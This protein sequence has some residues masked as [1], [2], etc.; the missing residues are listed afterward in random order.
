M[1][2]NLNRNL[3]LGFGLSVLL[4]VL[5]SIASY[6]SIR[7]LVESAKLVDHSTT[8]VQ[9]LELIISTMKDAETGQRGYLLTGQQQFL[10]PYRG[11]SDN[12]LDLVNEVQE[13]TYDDSSQQNHIARIKE[14]LQQRLGIL[15]TLIDKKDAGTHVSAADLRNGKLAMDELRRAVDI[16]EVS[17]R[18]VLMERTD[19]LTRLSHVTPIILLFAVLLAI[20]ISILFY[21]RVSKDIQEKVALQESL[22]E[23]D[24]DTVNRIR[25][26]QR[27]AAGISAG[28][29]G[30][31]LDV[32]GED[33]LGAISTALNKMA[34]NLEYSFNRI[35]ENEWMQTGLNQLN[36]KMIGE[37]GIGTLCQEA[38]EFL[39]DYTE[40]QV[41]AL[42]LLE[43]KVL[44]LESGFAVRDAPGHIPLGQGL[45]GHAALNNTEVWL[46]DMPDEY[47]TV[48]HATGEM[49][50]RHLII[51]PIRYE[52]GI[53]GVIEI[54]SIH[55]YKQKTL[56][57]LKNVSPN[58]ATVITRAEYRRRRQE[59]LEE[60]QAQSEELQ[61]Q[62][63][64]M[65]NLNAEL[66]AHTQ[67]LLASEEELRVQQEELQQRND[68]LA[69]RNT[70]ITQRN[71]EIRQTA[72]ELEQT[73]RYKSQFMANMSHELRTPLN[74][75]LLLSR[76]LTENAEGN[77][78]A[79]QMESVEVILNSGQG[80]L[81]LIDE[82]LDL[83]KI[84]AGKMELE[85]LS[86]AIDEILH[87]LHALFVP[88][89]D[90]KKLDL[91]MRNRLGASA[92]IQTDRMRL[93]QI[94]KNLLSNAL[95]FTK[96][97]R[98]VLEVRPADGEAGYLEF[99]VRDTGFGIA[100]EKLHLVF[101]AFQQV[102]GSTSRRFGG[103][104]LGLSISQ[105]FARLLGGRIRVTS[106]PGKGSEFVVTVPIA[107]EEVPGAAEP[108]PV[109]EAPFAAQVPRAERFLALEIPAGLEDDR[110]LI[111][112]GDKVVLI[113][114]D[115]TG[116]AS[117][118]LR[119]TRKKGYR[120]LVAVRGDEGLRL[121]Q[122]YLPI[123]I[124]LDIRLP[125]MDGW[126]VMDALKGN[127]ATRAIPVHMMS[128]TDS[129]KQ[130][131]LKGA[132]DFISK[133]VALEK[134]KELFDKLEDVWERKQKKVLIIEE[135]ARHAKALSNFLESF[136]V[137]S[138]ISRTVG[139]SVEALQTRQV[140]CVILDMG[141]PDR[142]A[143]QT[144]ETIKQ[145]PGLEDLPIIIFTGKHLS[146]GEESRIR[147]YADTI[148]VKTAHS[149]Q[150]ILDEVTLFL[151]LVE[152]QHPPGGET[153]GRTPELYNETLKGKTVLIA[154]DDVRNI[155]SMTKALEMQG[156]KVISTMDG[157]EAL[158][159]LNTHPEV[160]IVLMDM[161]MPEM[162]GYQ[163]MT[164]IR[165]D[166]RFKNIPMIAVTAKAML[167]DRE[168]C[169]AAGASDYISKP[170]DIDQLTSLLRVWLFEKYKRK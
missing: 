139:E 130:S 137:S 15:Q 74:S 33:E 78:S 111:G 80:L 13:M 65:E 142:N 31:R 53:K 93:E 167:G 108:L 136:D 118:L 147:Q 39:G 51:M 1:K 92:R 107:R 126:E 76:Y 162:D 66:E 143:Y 161:M 57:F 87:D 152:N 135:N 146:S 100:E 26:I 67:K 50:P 115:D 17:G 77:L 12:A 35:S 75:I 61:A 3:Q 56:E 121:A 42:Y 24:R 10:Q 98:V 133:P 52:D 151:H 112:Q 36:T 69:E 103:T 94:L 106:E 54:G 117:V 7:N 6:I 96:T 156:M 71:R 140:D 105:E 28:N 72:K 102:D 63:A 104:G 122:K 120:G 101:E 113:I 125:V 60:T 164:K 159:Q 43:G 170:V 165:Q 138:I 34:E 89:A 55:P 86:V 59:L 88:V 48:S 119:F 149:Y 81:T 37:K 44:R 68:E 38:M 95:K 20:V 169:I 134:L 49:R 154:D 116:F 109:A 11:A 21:I 79:E 128:V 158:I 62:H 41:G 19:R 153:R 4:L 155:F 148:V 22:E 168:K 64:E 157:K 84:E 91:V 150:R 160:S 82:L 129:R 5:S 144:L 70:L 16:A 131:R 30:I 27:L 90:Q 18:A 166:P 110:A 40:S 99:S 47:I 29:Y 85:Y 123:A 73:T 127:A 23:R 45:I 14:V 25:L 145:H 2:T 97:G 163:T 83:S 132:I 141:I 8:V 58:I 32:Q 114:E 46:Q 124:L 9:K